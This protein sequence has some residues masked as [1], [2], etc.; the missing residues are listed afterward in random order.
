MILAL[1]PAFVLALTPM[2]LLWWFGVAPL[3]AGFYWLC[4][5]QWQALQQSAA[6]ALQ[7]DGQLRWFGTAL[8]PGKL[9]DAGLISQHAIRLCWRGETDKRHYQRWIF[10]D[11]CPEADFR[12]LARVINQRNWQSAAADTSPG[13]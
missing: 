11:Q 8:P 9:S 1:M 12:A 5:G 3:L 13:A 6:L 10:A 2:P 4:Y 7:A